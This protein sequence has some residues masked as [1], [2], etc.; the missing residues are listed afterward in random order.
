VGSNLDLKG[1]ELDNAEVN[2]NGSTGPFTQNVRK[3][4]DTMFTK[5]SSTDEEARQEFKF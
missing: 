4:A 5:A 2:K 3:R 1:L